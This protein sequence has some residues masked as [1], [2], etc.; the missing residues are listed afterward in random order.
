MSKEIKRLQGPEWYAKKDSLL[1]TK[2][3]INEKGHIKGTY[4]DMDGNLYSHWFSNKEVE[5]FKEQEK[6]E[7]IHFNNI[8]NYKVGVRP[9]GSLSMYHIPDEEEDAVTAYKEAIHHMGVD[10]G[11]G[12]DEEEIRQRFFET[13]KKIDQAKGPDCTNI[14]LNIPTISDLDIERSIDNVLS[15]EEYIKEIHDLI[16]EDEKERYVRALLNRINKAITV[17]EE[18]IEFCKNDSQGVYD[19]CNMAIKREEKVIAI[20][21]GD[22]HE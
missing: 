3:R 22:K 14:S 19:K 21:K 2:Y 8:G 20:L 10:F 17:L 4:T 6:E 13:H 12:P 7:E 18:G 16:L 1:M 11:K 5:E 15:C 9:N